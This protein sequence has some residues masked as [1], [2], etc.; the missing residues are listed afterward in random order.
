MKRARVLALAVLVVAA[1]GDRGGTQPATQAAAASG[2][3]GAAMGA[4]A[5]TAPHDA[6]PRDAARELDAEPLGARAMIEGA[7]AEAI[8]A[9]Q[10]APDAAPGTPT[11]GVHA[12]GAGAF[13]LGAPHATVAALLGS[14]RLEQTAAPGAPAT[15]ATATLSGADGGPLLELVIVGG[16]LAAVHIVAR[17]PRYLTDGGIG[18]GS[19][20][21]EAI[22]AHGEARD[23]GKLTS[24]LHAKSD[25]A[26]APRGK[27]S[28]AS[29][30]RATTARRGWILSD[31]PGVVLVGTSTATP[32]A[33]AQ[34]DASERI[35]RL[36][37]LGNLADD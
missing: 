2:V 31:L 37:V 10:P 5:V 22:R 28:L 27:G 26:G 19:T 9:A 11:T 13:A 34:P 21:D 20:F 12:R 7:E 4:Q 3:G 15:L 33:A 14:A 23:A 32:A 6:A 24:S 30:R 16:R 29:S 8:L 17:D 25:L 36:V 18:P 1:C 35:T